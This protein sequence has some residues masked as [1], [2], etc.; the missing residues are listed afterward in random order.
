MARSTEGSSVN[1]IT[2]TFTYLL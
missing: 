2:I 1:D